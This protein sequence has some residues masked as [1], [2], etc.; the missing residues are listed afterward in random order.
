MKRNIIETVLGGVVLLV[1]VGFLIFAFQSSGL[2]SSGGGYQITAEFTDASGWVDLES[3]SLELVLYHQEVLGATRHKTLPSYHTKLEK[4][5][6]VLQQ[7]HSA[8]QF[9]NIWVREL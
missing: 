4:G 3:P 8:V 5:P 1:A 2:S 9:R 7:H 6:I